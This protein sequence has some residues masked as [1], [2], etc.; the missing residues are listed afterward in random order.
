MPRP[1]AILCTA[2][3]PQQPGVACCPSADGGPEALGKRQV[4]LFIIDRCANLHHPFIMVSVSQFSRAGAFG[5]KLK[6]N[7]R[8]PAARPRVAVMVVARQTKKEALLEAKK[9]VENL[10]KSKHCHPI[11]VRLAWHDSGSYDK[12]LRGAFLRACRCCCACSI[13]WRQ[14]AY[15]SACGVRAAC[16]AGC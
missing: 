14:R 4:L 7:S 8:T 3:R 13:C 6:S 1:R 10:I 15:A 9:D 16:C 2:P 12:V 5:N 11:V